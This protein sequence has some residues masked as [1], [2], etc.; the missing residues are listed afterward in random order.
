MPSHVINI[1]THTV[2]R[3]YTINY[4]DLMLVGGISGNDWGWLSCNKLFVSSG[5]QL[6]GNTQVVNGDFDVIGGV[7]RFVQ[8]HPTDP[9]KVIRYIS[10]ESG[11]ALTITRGT[12]R[13]V[14]GQVTVALPEHFSLVTSDSEPITVILTSEGA[15]AVLYTKEKSREQIIVAMRPSDFS[16]FKDVEFSFQVTGVRDGFERQEIIV[17]EGMLGGPSVMREDVQN[18]VNAFAERERARQEAIRAAREQEIRE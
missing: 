17:D 16:E 1:R 18:R 7:K 10:M 14:N 9:S 4:G 11:E 8:P 6:T 15:P 12:A 5:S 13:T 2:P 3:G